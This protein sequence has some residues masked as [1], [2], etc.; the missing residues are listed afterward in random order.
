MSVWRRPG[1]WLFLLWTSVVAA[2][3]QQTLLQRVDFRQQP[4]AQVADATQWRDAR[5]R[6]RA[7]KSVQDGRPML[8]VLSWFGCEGLCPVLLENLRAAQSSLGLPVDDYRIVAVSID[9]EEG[10]EDGS[11]MAHHLSPRGTAE[12]S[13]WAF[14]TGTHAAITRLSDSVGFDY[15]YD[16]QRDRFAHP[17]GLVVIAPDGKI[18]RYLLG[19]RPSA[20]DLRL[21]LV[22]AS[23]GRL[24]S[25]LQKTL[26]RC[27]HFDPETG[28]YN[29][30]VMRLLQVLGVVFLFAL[31]VML[32][33]L[34]RRRA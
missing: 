29:L 23:E 14:L 25:V 26:L 20:R 18:N 12:L 1:G 22:A 31:A 6:T 7:L 4:G 13:N 8:L 5:G 21:A 10:P 33:Y 34:Q 9:P 2:A 27:Y 11:N 17:A 30:A 15:V 28:Q 32:V 19:L 24:G 3:P 16:A